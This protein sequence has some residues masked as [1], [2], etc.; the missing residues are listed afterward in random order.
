LGTKPV[1]N[2]RSFNES[3][4][5]NRASAAGFKNID[6]VRNFQKEYNQFYKNK[7]GFIPLKEDGLFGDESEKALL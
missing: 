2:P 4:W 3:Y 1:G 7:A 6:D 5:V